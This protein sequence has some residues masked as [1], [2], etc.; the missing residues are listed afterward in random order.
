MNQGH[1]GQIAGYLKQL[2]DNDHA[3]AYLI[4][5]CGDAYVQFMRS[6]GD[7]GLYCEAVSNRNLPKQRQLNAAQMQHFAQWGF[8]LGG[9]DNYSSMLALTDP[10]SLDRIARLADQILTEVYGVRPVDKLE[11]ELNT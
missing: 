6:E 7:T 2:M 10:D 9:S 4:V 8:A 11:F 1:A 3:D 5:S